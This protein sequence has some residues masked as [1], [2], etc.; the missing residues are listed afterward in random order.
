MSVYKK[1]YL[2]NPFSEDG[3]L[4]RSD[5][6]IICF[7]SK[8]FKCNRI[9]LFMNPIIAI[10]FDGALF[11]SRPFDEAHKRWFRLFSILLD[12]DSINDWA[13]KENYFE[14]VH[15]CMKKYLGDTDN[16]SQTFFSRQI[17]A[18]M[19]VAETVSSD[20]VKEFA[21]YLRSI[22]GR[23][24]LALITSAPK[25]AA[26]PM[27]HKT[28][29]A[30]LF[31]IIYYSPST[32]HPDKMSLFGEFITKHERPLFYIGKGDKDLGALK[33]L[34]INTISVNW[35]EKGTFKGSHDIYSV[36]ELK[37]IL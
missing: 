25:S 10:D 15:L 11:R 36:D 22:K 1:I 16:E 3:T 4:L 30:D 13:F 35:V 32:D 29:C 37:H 33:E 9:L 26:L 8:K 20:M 28:H 24:S 21:E 7:L 14:G 12:D 17:Y 18:M 31:D 2:D 5:V 19:L 6:F 23:Y 34:G 27:L